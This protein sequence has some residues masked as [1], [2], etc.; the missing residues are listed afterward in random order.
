MKGTAE[1]IIGV[2]A[3]PRRITMT[4]SLD[5]SSIRYSLVVPIYGDADFAADFLPAF[6]KAFQDFL[7]KPE[8]VEDVELIFV[9][10]GGPP[11]QFGLLKGTV[12]KYA[13]ARV[14]ELSR[15]FG[16][17]VALSCGYAHARGQYV[18]ML[19]IDMQDPPD[20]IPVLL[21]PLERGEA[22]IVTGLREGDERAFKDRVTSTL[23]N[24]FLNKLTGFDTPLNVATL[25]MMN[26]R[27]TDAY[28]SLSER[29]RYLP[30]LEKWLGFTHLYVP[31]RHQKRMKGKSTYNFRR[32]LSMALNSVIS[33]SDLP[34]RM[35]ATVGLG[36]AMAGFLLAGVLLVQ[37]LFSAN[38]LPGFVSTISAIMMVGGIQ[39]LVT[40]VASLYIGRILTEVQGR[41]LY[42]VK[43][44]L[45]FPE[46]AP[47][48]NP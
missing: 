39:I 37:R 3:R 32:R 23:F 45:N 42:V 30:G 20:Q 4:T 7:K 31:I 18:G 27:F 8:I 26:R 43:E 47:K 38:F 11:G 2:T 41:P 12:Q 17:H 48:K 34:L 9:I 19:N 10:D 29:S 46:D 1:P 33:F 36:I 5:F 6:E 14:L 16:Q 25:R 22:D 28:N 24:V 44:R 21:G 40:G 13:F 35:L 15:N